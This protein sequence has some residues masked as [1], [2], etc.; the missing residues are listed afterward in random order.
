MVCMG[1]AVDRFVEIVWCCLHRRGS[2]KPLRRARC[3]HPQRSLAEWFF[4][5]THRNRERWLVSI[6]R[7]KTQCCK[8]RLRQSETARACV[9]T[10]P[11]QKTLTEPAADP[12]RAGVNAPSGWRGLDKQMLSVHVIDV[13]AMRQMN[14]FKISPRLDMHITQPGNNN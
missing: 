6:Y 4:C 9:N 7:S 13:K 8:M 11:A 5:G 12:L 14:D 10:W 2:A 1:S 3:G